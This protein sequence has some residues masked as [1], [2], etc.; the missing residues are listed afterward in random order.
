M[1]Y[2]GQSLVVASAMGLSASMLC[3]TAG[4]AQVSTTYT[5]DALGRL[6]TVTTAGGATVTY[7]YDAAGNR[8]QVVVAGV[9]T[10]PTAFDLGAAVTGATA[11]AWLLSAAPVVSGFTGAVAVSVTGGQYRINGGA[12]QTA[13]GTVSAGQA[14]QVQVQASTTPGASQTATLN[15]G[16]VT[17]TFQVTTAAADTTP[18][19]YDLGNP[20][21][22]ASGAWST[23]NTVTIAGIDAATAVSISGGQYR[24]NGGAWTTANGTITAGQTIQVQVQAPA[25]G[26]ASQTATLNV[27]GVTDTFQVTATADATPDAYDLGNPVAAASG[28]WSASSTV[29]I[30]GINAAAA[31]SITGGQYRINGGA[32]TTTAGTVSA[33]QTVQVQVQAPAT[34]GANQTATL[35]VGGVTDTFQVTATADTTPDAYD[36]GGP[37]TGASG[38]WSAS[39]TVTIAG[40][41]ASAAVSISGGQYRINGGAWATTAGTV[42]A[43]QTVQVQVQAPSAGGANQT[44][45]LNVGG[46]TDTFQVTTAADYTLDALDWSNISGT[47]S[48]TNFVTGGTALPLNG[49][50]SNVTLRGTIT[51]LSGNLSAGSR[52]EMW[53]NGV[54]RYHSTNLGNGS[55]PG[56]EFAPGETVQFVARAVSADGAQRLGS[57]TVT[58]QNLTTGQTIDTFTVAQ[59][60][61]APDYTPE[62]FN[63]FTDQNAVTNDPTIWFGPAQTVTGINQPVTLRVE[64]YNYSGNFNEIYVNVYRDSGSGWVHQGSFDP[65]N[66]GYQYVDFTV[67][68]GDKVHYA[69]DARTYEGRKTG[70]MNMVVW[71]LSQPGGAAQLS[72]R[73]ATMTVDNDN[74]YNIPDYTLDGISIP[75][76]SVTSNDNAAWTNTAMLTVAGI[77]RPVTL[78]FTRGNQSDSFAAGSTG[79]RRLHVF[80]STNNGASW[81]E[82]VLTDASAV[83]DVTVNN[84]D[85]IHTRALFETTTGRGQSSFSGYI[86]NLQTGAQLAAFNVSGVVD[87]DNNYNIGG[88]VAATDWPMVSAW[89]N[90][91]NGSSQS[92]NYSTGAARTIS[93]LA[94]GQTAT[95]T[96]SAVVDGD[97]SA[98]LAV[99]IVKNGVDQGLRLNSPAY[100]SSVS[101]SAATVT[102]QNGDQIAFKAIVN[103]DTA[104]LS[105]P[106]VFQGKEMTVT[107]HAVPGGA[108]D[109]FVASGSYSDRYSSG[110]G[111]GEGPIILD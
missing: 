35:T 94:A 7:A 47:S 70:T 6:K 24:I 73:T 5:Y 31:V 84:G 95:L 80:H 9:Q 78:R 75:T 87:A 43:G 103:G 76:L 65:R 72:N 30:T 111:G 64:R 4:H 42:S 98:A 36:L 26:G 81:I 1:R 25:T 105:N 102:V 50:N 77:N 19:A 3:P 68:N 53:V 69:V 66:S 106:Q 54:M 18:N 91:V 16:G 40:I 46:V 55:W 62:V 60:A 71:N 23:S 110:N 45:T 14:V 22:A 33:G 13:A 32:W 41:N 92:P 67:N 8:S 89:W 99:N 100:S 61:A 34:A 58:V 52:L 104:T 38:A 12:W 29:T 44:A 90:S 59:T 108:V 79:T 107:V 86:T 39:N 96:L 28:A 2:M 101:T 15:V 27:G 51:N 97:T 17:D 37:V 83:L 21:T 82:H 49:V 85:L 10:G 11:G 109:T 56:G 48:S 93:G 63:D 57:Y 74:N 88:N 20:V